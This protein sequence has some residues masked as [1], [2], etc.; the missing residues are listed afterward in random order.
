MASTM[1]ASA[2]VWQR[3]CAKRCDHA[4]SHGAKAMSK[5]LGWDPGQTRDVV[6]E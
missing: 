6:S 2:S 4:P 5:P 3:E 1:V